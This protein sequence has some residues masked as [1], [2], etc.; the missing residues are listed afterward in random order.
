MITGDYHHTGIAVARDVGM[1]K[2][3]GHVVVIDSTPLVPDAKLLHPPAIKSVTASPSRRTVKRSVSF[4]LK[5]QT[6]STVKRSAGFAAN[7]ND[8]DHVAD[9]DASPTGV[10]AADTLPDSL[11]AQ[12]CASGSTST[13]PLLTGDAQSA[14]EEG[15][16]VHHST[17]HDQVPVPIMDPRPTSGP[18][19]EGLRFLTVRQEPLEASEALRALGEGQMQC[20]VTGDALTYLL[21]HHDLSVLET[22][23]RNV[24]VFSRMKPDQKGQVMD[25]LGM[26]G[27]HQRFQGQARYIP[28]RF[29]CH[30]VVAD[31]LPLMHEFVAHAIS[32]TQCAW[33]ALALQLLL[34]HAASAK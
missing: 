25:L 29:G 7:L 10:H 32:N 26:A 24:I 9:Q 6:R 19:L 12:E 15:Q 1:L 31:H 16:W 2:P 20:A 3:P 28:V 5:T 33:L 8:S 13:Q 18:L 22:V 34:F 14:A 27:I 17:R 11:L 23:M 30:T 4:A 21:Q